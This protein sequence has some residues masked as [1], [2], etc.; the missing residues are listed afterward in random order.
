MSVWLARTI[1]VRLVSD[2]TYPARHVHLWLRVTPATRATG[3]SWWL[4]NA[5]ANRHFTTTMW[6]CV[7]AATYPAGPALVHQNSTAQAVIAMPPCSHRCASSTSTV[8]AGYSMAGVSPS[9]PTFRILLAASV[10]DAQPT[11]RHASVR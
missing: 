10:S 4:A 9:V 6:P 5:S 11:V 1:P 7:P 2:A 3:E 8:L